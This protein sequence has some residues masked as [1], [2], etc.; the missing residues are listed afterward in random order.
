MLVVGVLGAGL[1]VGEDVGA[2]RVPLQVLRVAGR[3]GVG[4]VRVGSEAQQLAGGVEDR[5]LAVADLQVALV[6]LPPALRHL[7]PRRFEGVVGAGELEFL[8]D[9]G[10]VEVGG[11]EH[12]VAVGDVHPGHQGVVQTGVDDLVPG[13]LALPLGQVVGRSDVC[14]SRGTGRRLLGRLLASGAGFPGCSPGR[15]LGRRLGLR[16]R[17]GGPGRSGRRGGNLDLRRLRLSPGTPE[18]RVRNARMHRLPPTG[19]QKCARQTVKTGDPTRSPAPHK[20][21]QDT[22]KATRR[23][24]EGPMHAGRN[25]P[26]RF[27]RTK[28]DFKT[29]TTT[30]IGRN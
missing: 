11:R 16:L 7:P 5:C 13:H 23:A 14:G 29:S 18:R 10:D 17:A 19:S 25:Q 3:R 8:A 30:I 4:A 28:R 21:S 24:L 2:V 20:L 1:A 27:S 26:H 15:D 9:A 22:H 12:Q 6:S